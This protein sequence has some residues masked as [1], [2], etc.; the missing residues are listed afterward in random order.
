MELTEK[1]AG[2]KICPDIGRRCIGSECMA[3]KWTEFKNEYENHV[4]QCHATKTY[5]TEMIAV[6]LPVKG[7]CLKYRR[8]GL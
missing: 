3:W 6:N 4:V 2:K 1:E 5:T 8:R 7:I